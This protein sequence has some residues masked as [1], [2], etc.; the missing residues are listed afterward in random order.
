MTRVQFPA[1]TGIFF[2]LPLHPDQLWSPPSLL[3]SGYWGLF[4]PGH[5]TDHLPPSNAEVKIAWK[6]PSTKFN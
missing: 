4:P 3:S 5:G 1:G 2:S 6:V